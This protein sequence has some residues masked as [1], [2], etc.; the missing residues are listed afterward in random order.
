[1]PAQ[2]SR[3]KDDAETETT[4]TRLSTNKLRYGCKKQPGWKVELFTAKRLCQSVTLSN[5]NTF[6]L[7]GI[8]LHHPSQN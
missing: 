5:I 4:E 7:I 8:F 3:L 2:H 6:F 1:M